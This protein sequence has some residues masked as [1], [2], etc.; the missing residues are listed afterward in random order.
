[1]WCKNNSSLVGAFKISD[2]KIYR[3]QYFSFFSEMRELSNLLDYM[4][5]DTHNYNFMIRN[6]SQTSAKSHINFKAPT[7]ILGGWS[8]LEIWY[9]CLHQS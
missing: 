3:L 7:L 2:W 9:V 5:I 4:E 6:L 1:M 8:I